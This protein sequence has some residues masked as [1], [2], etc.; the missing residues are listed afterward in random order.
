MVQ[1][2]STQGILC[3]PKMWN[4]WI[5]AD[6][7]NAHANTLI[8]M[9]S[10]ASYLQPILSNSNNI[11]L[12][13]SVTHLSTTERKSLDDIK[14]V[15]CIA[16]VGFFIYLKKIRKNGK[17]Q[18][19]LLKKLEKANQWSRLMPISR[20]GNHDFPSHKTEGGSWTTSS[21]LYYLMIW[22]CDKGGCSG[23]RR[24]MV[25]AYFGDR[26]NSRRFILFVLRNILSTVF[27]FEFSSYRRL[28][29]IL[30]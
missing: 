9:S 28:N 24:K 22:N 18:R 26:Q 25:I 5:I 15:T 27:F 30:W 17:A 20:S 8:K 29:R 11:L 3:L 14:I 10:F 7:I 23:I 21:L 12:S 2:I 1:N 6:K 16:R 13:Y 19:V 4:S